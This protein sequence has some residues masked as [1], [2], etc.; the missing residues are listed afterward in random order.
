MFKEK[1]KEIE[2]YKE[3]EEKVGMLINQNNELNQIMNLHGKETEF[4]MD[5]YKK[6]EQ[7]LAVDQG[8][9]N[10]FQNKIEYL[11]TRV[12]ELLEENQELNQFFQNK[13]S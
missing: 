4:W 5:N 6:I 2:G 10:E 13:Y 7:Q 12:N 1:C 9:F 8:K 3:L 11:E